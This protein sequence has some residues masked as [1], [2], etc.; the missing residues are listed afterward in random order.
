MLKLSQEK[1]Q[2]LLESTKKSILISALITVVSVGMTKLFFPLM[3]AMVAIF[4]GV[5]LLWL[6]TTAFNSWR[7][8]IRYMEEEFKNDPK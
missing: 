4:A 3:T 2:Q 6:L 7:F 8:L 1:T 5:I